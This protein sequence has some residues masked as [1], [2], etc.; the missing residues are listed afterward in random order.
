MLIM[1]RGIKRYTATKRW[2]YKKYE[3]GEEYI[4]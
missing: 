4:Y 2:N 3:G 1:K